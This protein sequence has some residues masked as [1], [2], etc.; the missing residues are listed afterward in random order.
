MYEIL[1]LIITGYSGGSYQS[2]C[3][4]L[5]GGVWTSQ[6]RMQKKIYA[7]AAS[8][9]DD[10]LLVTGGWDGSYHSSTEYFSSGQWVSGPALPVTMYNHCQVTVGTVVI[11]TGSGIVTVQIVLVIIIFIGGYTSSKLASVYKLQAGVWTRLPDMARARYAHSCEV[12]GGHL[13]VM[14]GDGAGAVEMMN[15]STQKWQP[16]PELAKSFSSG[17]A[18]V[19]RSTLFLV[20]R[21]GK[22]V[23]LTDAAKWEDVANIG[24]I[25]TRPVFPAQVVTAGVLGC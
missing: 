6:P 12:V 23:K 7:A 25:G 4:S 3:H 22:V 18:V 10:G 24:P 20:S 15:I 5:V 8:M 16:G 1:I 2:S 13:F 9:T 19:Y 21:E 11:V 14:G 17:Q